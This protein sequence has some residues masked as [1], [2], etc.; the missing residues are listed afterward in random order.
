VEVSS[1]NSPPENW[2]EAPK[3]NRIPDRLPTIIFGGAKAYSASSDHE[4]KLQTVF[5]L[6]HTVDG[7]NPANHQG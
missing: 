2:R 3:G 1:N 5:F 7:Q 4:I 6:Q